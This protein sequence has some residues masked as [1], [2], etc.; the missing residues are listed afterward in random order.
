MKEYATT[1]K[2]AD[3]GLTWE[4]HRKEKKQF[5]T[6]DLKRIFKFCVQALGEITKKDFEESILS[7]IKHILPIVENVLTWRFVYRRYILLLQT[8]LELISIKDYTYR[9]SL[10]SQSISYIIYILNLILIMI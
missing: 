7:L 2:S 8:Y 5:E 9:K 10:T 1:T 6:T 4:T 3:I